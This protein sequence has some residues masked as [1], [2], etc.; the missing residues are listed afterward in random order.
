MFIFQIIKPALKANCYASVR[1]SATPEEAMDA[2]CKA[3]AIAAFECFAIGNDITEWRPS[4][5]CGKLLE[6]K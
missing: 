1:A 4:K 3:V 2:A 5:K 6:V